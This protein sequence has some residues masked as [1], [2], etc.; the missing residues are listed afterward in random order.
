MRCISNFL[1]NFAGLWSIN[2]HEIE[3]LPIFCWFCAK[4]TVE[5]SKWI[6]I[7]LLGYDTLIHMRLKTSP[8]LGW[9]CAKMTV[10]LSKW[11][12]TIYII[13]Y[14]QLEEHYQKTDVPSYNFQIFVSCAK[15]GINARAMKTPIFMPAF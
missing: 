3:N 11:I 4:L 15:Y 5:L 12:W 1:N 13:I 14:W 9:L 10:E 7:I 6:E 8:F 2:S